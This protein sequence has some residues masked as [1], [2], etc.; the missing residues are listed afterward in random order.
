MNVGVGSHPLLPGTPTAP[1]SKYPYRVPKDTDFDVAI[2]SATRKDGSPSTD[3]VRFLV[4]QMNAIF[5][6]T[7]PGQVQY[8]PF[9]ASEGSRT[10]NPV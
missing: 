9:G 5:S 3:R 1:A 8:F 2:P 4:Y 6:V 10:L 7:N